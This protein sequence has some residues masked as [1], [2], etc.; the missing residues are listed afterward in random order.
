MHAVDPTLEETL[1]ACHHR[2]AAAQRRLYEQYFSFARS[3][4][5]HYG[6]N[7]SEAEEIVQ[8]AFLKL[9]IRLDQSPFTGD[10]KKWFRRIV[11]N[12]GI[13]HYR[14]NRRH[15]RLVGQ[16]FM[17]QEPTVLNEANAHLADEDLYRLLQFLPPAYRLAYNLHVIEGYS[18]PEI[19]EQLGISEGTSK[20]NLSKAR[21][22]LKVLAEHF[23]A[24]ST[25]VS[26]G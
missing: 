21:R 9:F 17:N 10:F 11:V 25:Q 23:F 16:L 14:S 26:N 19:A 6:S 12:A 13:D 20:S 24:T 2:D 22:K 18:H 7:L 8:D 5:L 4:A 1:L 15:R 3:I